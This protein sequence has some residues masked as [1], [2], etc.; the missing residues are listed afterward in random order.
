MI[1]AL[2]PKKAPPTTIKR[3]PVTVPHIAVGLWV[4]TIAVLVLPSPGEQRHRITEAH[5]LRALAKDRIQEKQ[6]KSKKAKGKR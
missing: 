4:A 2:A 3:H 5:L 1:G 6:G